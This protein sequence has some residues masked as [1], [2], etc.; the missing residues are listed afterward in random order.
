VLDQPLPRFFADNHA[1]AVTLLRLREP[2]AH[3]AL[4]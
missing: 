2:E 4:I 3:S 1:R